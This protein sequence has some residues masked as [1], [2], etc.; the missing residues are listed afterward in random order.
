M[1]ECGEVR[2]SGDMTCDWGQAETR[3]LP[4]CW[5]WNS[6]AR[7]VTSQLSLT[8]VSTCMRM[9]EFSWQQKEGQKKVAQ[10]RK[11]F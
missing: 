3:G 7:A 5:S 6:R 1:S 9:I 4:G 10:C 2:E 11:T 8:T